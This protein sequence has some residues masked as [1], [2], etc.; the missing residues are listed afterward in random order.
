MFVFSQLTLPPL[1][2]EKE[3]CV[4]KKLAILFFSLVLAT[5]VL[6]E[7]CT[8][9]CGPAGDAGSCSDCWSGSGR[10]RAQVRQSLADLEVRKD[11]VSVE[12]WRRRELQKLAVTRTRAAGAAEVAA[13]R[14]QAEAEVAAAREAI[15]VAASKSATA[16]GG[17]T[18]PPPPIEGEEYYQI[19]NNRAERIDLFGDEKPMGISIEPGTTKVVAATPGTEIGVQISVRTREVKDG[20][21]KTS[22]KNTEVPISMPPAGSPD[23]V[24]TKSDDGQPIT[25]YILKVEP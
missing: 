3:K 23:T 21:V 8:I 14:G 24:E 20:K 7:D 6:A 17:P 4:M 5:P 22:I 2:G 11:L 19:T 16:A 25:A 12:K 13:A 18:A 9:L 1:A 10:G 15:A